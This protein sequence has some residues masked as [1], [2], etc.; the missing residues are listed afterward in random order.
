M[1]GA[2]GDCAQER[3]AIRPPL[4]GAHSPVLAKR[5]RSTRVMIVHA[6]AITRRSATRSTNT[7][8]RHEH[9][10]P[11][12]P[13]KWKN[14]APMRYNRRTDTRSAL[15][16]ES[17]KRAR[18]ARSRG[19]C[20]RLTAYLRSVRRAMP[21]RVRMPLREIENAS[22][23]RW[24]IHAVHPSAKRHGTPRARAASRGR[25]PRSDAERRPPLD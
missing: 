6:A 14:M 3:C 2:S 18:R 21:S 1:N 20:P 25:G 4:E 23:A 17:S 24:T 9:H 22:G 12:I 19:V 16:I 15:E 11:D 5:R 7:G 8:R 13:R 10:A